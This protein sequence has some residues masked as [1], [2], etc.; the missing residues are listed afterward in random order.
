MASTASQC[1]PRVPSMAAS[2]AWNGLAAASTL[3][4]MSASGMPRTC[5]VAASSGASAGSPLAAK[6]RASISLIVQAA[7]SP[8][9][10]PAMIWLRCAA[11]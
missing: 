4:A 1:L 2:A 7:I 8:A 10:M 5:A 11:A 3:S 9:L 6:A